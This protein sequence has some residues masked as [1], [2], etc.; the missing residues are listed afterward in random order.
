MQRPERVDRKPLCIGYNR[1]SR[2]LILHHM[3]PPIDP[4][5]YAFRGGGL[6]LL[7]ISVAILLMAG[8]QGHALISDSHII[9]LS[10]A[11]LC[12][13]MCV[14]LLTPVVALAAVIEEAV[15]LLSS[16]SPDYL[17]GGLTMVLCFSCAILGAG[18]Y[19][20]EVLLFR[21]K[22]TVLSAS[23]SRPSKV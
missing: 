1:P 4:F 2:R 22:R 23:R 17:I 11:G 14:G 6:L 19:S 16:N 13:C 10:A 12:L 15:F 3:P 18:A 5:S 20:L 8:G 9:S 21:R 7:R